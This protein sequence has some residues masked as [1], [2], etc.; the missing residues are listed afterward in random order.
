MR[1]IGYLVLINNAYPETIAFDKEEALEIAKRFNPKA[2]KL[3]NRKCNERQSASELAKILAHDNTETREDILNRVRDG[4][5]TFF[6]R[7]YSA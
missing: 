5:D 3:I 6:K 1:A 2:V 7:K 4:I